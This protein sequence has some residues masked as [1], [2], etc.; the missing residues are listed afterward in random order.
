M[1][2]SDKSTLGDCCQKH[3]P[4]TAP[5]VYPHHAS[6]ESGDNLR[7][8]YRCACGNEWS[9]WWSFDGAGRRSEPRRSGLGPLI[10]ARY[11]GRCS[12]CDQDIRRGDQI[13]AD[14]EGGWLCV[15]CA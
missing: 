14:G 2:D 10:E 8:E 1:S 12:G 4:M 5:V 3:P 6:R 15:S 9:C 11:S 13:R 7:A